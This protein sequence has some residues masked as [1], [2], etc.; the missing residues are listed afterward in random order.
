MAEPHVPPVTSALPPGDQPDHLDEMSEDEA[1]LAALGY[2]QEFKVRKINF[3][4][5]DVRGGL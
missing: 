1:A 5:S 4:P 2:K 3:P